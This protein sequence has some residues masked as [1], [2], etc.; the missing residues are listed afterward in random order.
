MLE[1][2][3]HT[4]PAQ[5]VVAGPR[6]IDAL[7]EHLRALGVR[8]AVVLTS[9]GRAE[10][11]T[12][13]RVQARA[14]RTLAQVLDL[15]EPHVPAPVVQR[16]VAEVQSLGADGL[17]SVGGG[18][19]VDTAKAVAFFLEH[20]AGTPGSG[21]ADRPAV[22]HVAVP[23]TLAGAAYTTSFSMIDPGSRRS[24]STAAPTLAPSSVLLDLEAFAELPASMLGQSVAVA[25]AHGL[26]A[27]WSTTASPEAR[28]L[29][30]AGI[31]RLAAAAPSAVEDPSD[32][33]ARGE[34]VAGAALCGRARQNDGDG[35]QQAL[36]QL[37]G[38]RSGA[39]HAAAHAA[40]LPHTTRLLADVVPT[41][42]VEAVAGALGGGDPADALAR[43]LDRLGAA[44]TL[45]E[46][47][48]DDEDLDAVARQSGA[49]RGVQTSLRPVGEGDVRALLE[50][51]C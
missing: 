8:R 26:E 45:G 17:I 46:L 41:G 16:A 24:T 13:E 20:Q 50:G 1:P 42:E 48:L 47:G 4:S 30:V 51:A 15:V 40:L 32:L 14:G 37:V 35:L 21:F 34:V 19:A 18:S 2:W 25:L 22:P 28:A 36:A 33:D 49:Q 10:S 12:L 31:A 7:S 5:Q 29:G 23:G 9:R 39:T 43:L 3:T 11:T 6:A 38:T 44:T 27:A